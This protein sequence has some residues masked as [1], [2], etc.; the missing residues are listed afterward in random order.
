MVPGADLSGSVVGGRYRLGALIGRGAMGAVYEATQEALGRP[1][2]VKVLLPQLAQDATHVAR[3]KTEAALA[4]SLSHPHVVQVYDFGAEPGMVWLAMERLQGES[5]RARI[6]RAG[7]LS[8]RE[9][10]SITV[11]MLRGLE[12]AHSMRLVHRDLKPDNVYLAQTPGMGEV[13][14]LVDFGIAKLLDAETVQKLTATGMMIGTP[15]YMAPEQITGGEVDARADI[16]GV[17]AVLFE[18]LAGR[19]PRE[20]ATYHALVHAILTEPPMPLAQARPDVD[21]RVGATIA[22]ALAR[23]PGARYASAA[24]MREELERVLADLPATEAPPPRPSRNLPPTR[25]APSVRAAVPTPTAAPIERGRS[26]VPIVIGGVLAAIG[27]AAAVV[28]VAT[29]TGRNG[30]DASEAHAGA[31]LAAEP[32]RT[33]QL[34]LESKD[35]AAP[36]DA[37][38]ASELAEA[39]AE[40]EEPETGRATRSQKRTRPRT[41][42]QMQ[43]RTEAQEPEPPSQPA[44][45][46][47]E[48]VRVRYSSI[49]SN[50]IYPLD[51]IRERVRPIVGDACWT[52][53][54]FPFPESNWGDCYDITSSAEGVVTNV[55]VVNALL[56]ERP[57]G[58][59]ECMYEKIRTIR[60]DPP[61]GD[62]GT[63]RV[64]WGLRN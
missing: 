11:Q 7:A 2:A 50:R 59:Y 38:A 31:S 4:G 41:D 13:V 47:A 26:L 21:P 36:H 16:H 62:W 33:E 3:F 25:E 14:K 32:P 57:P 46:A 1:V 63:I 52:P 37:Y 60:F 61:E 56:D 10:L 29:M 5:L 42:T 39:P 58:F 19:P 53:R 24:A 49:T 54:T 55:N 45:P 27:V 34:A 6:E 64:C 9:A 23:D 18:M 48:P 20:A 22:R 35:A 8:A 51:H 17:G 12:A 40:I 30:N 15:L 44:A 43:A 28:A